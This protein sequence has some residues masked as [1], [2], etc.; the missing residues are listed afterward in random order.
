M[1][2]GAS[3]QRGTGADTRDAVTGSELEFMQKLV[4]KC[5]RRRGAPGSILCYHRLTYYEGHHYHHHHQFLNSKG[6]WGTTDDFATSFLHFPLFSTAL[7]D[8]PNS[9][10]TK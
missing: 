7:T 8:L 3:S 10:Q 5:D 6:R 2:L 1:F 4:L 9:T